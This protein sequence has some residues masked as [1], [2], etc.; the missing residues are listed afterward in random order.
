LR[1]RGADVGELDD[2][3]FRRGCQLAEFGQVV[4]DAL[5]VAQ[6]FG[7]L[8]QDAS[9]QGDVAGFHRD[10][11]GLRVGGDD[12]QQRPGR[13]RGGLVGEG[14]EDLAVG[15]GALA[16]PLRGACHCR[17][18]GAPGAPGRVLPRPACRRRRDGP[19]SYW[20]SNSRVC[21]TMPLCEVS[22]LWVPA[23]QPSG[24]VI[25]KS[26]TCG[27]AGTDFSWVSTTWPSSKVHF[28]LR[29]PAV[30]PSVATD[31]WMVSPEAKVV[32]GVV[33]RL[34]SPVAEPRSTVVTVRPVG[35]VSM[36]S[37]PVSV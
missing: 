32:V 10:P 28:A 12:R 35:V 19:G 11:R 20:T 22:S 33:I 18:G 29:V 14:V 37:M 3:G 16:N 17:T 6:Q 13:Q 36:V 1:H 34:S 5:V 24:L 21:R 23:G 31:A 8:G 30:A 25:S 2:V 9:G 26:V 7:E 15:H 4:A 27:P